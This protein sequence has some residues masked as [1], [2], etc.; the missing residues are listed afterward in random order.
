VN[1][2][3]WVLGLAAAIGLVNLLPVLL[4]LKQAVTPEAESLSWP[5]TWIP[6]VWTTENFR[7]LGD[8]VELG[9]G[10][11]LSLLVAF[12]TVFST[13]AIALPAAWAA[14]HGPR[15]DRALDRVLVLARSFP[16]IA[17]GVPLASLFVGWGLYNSPWGLGLWLAHTLLALPLAFLILR[18]ALRDL[19]PSVIEAARLDGAGGGRLL[20]HVLLPLVRPS[21]AAAAMLVFLLSWDE[22]AYSLLLQVTNRPLPPLLF[23]LASF[24]YP[25]LASA[26]AAVM[27]VPALAIVAVLEPALRSGV[28]AGS[29]R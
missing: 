25:G 15:L 2:R 27:L 3:R 11:V 14:V 28:F 10:L 4:V 21:L 23:Y 26:V 22:L 18:N 19:P 16:T 5:P 1:G 20:W 24:G 17:V 9:S 29:S 6:H 8:A 13:I 12:L 7:N